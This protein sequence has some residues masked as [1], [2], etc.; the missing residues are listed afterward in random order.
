MLGTY[1]ASGFSRILLL[2]VNQP[3]RTGKSVRPTMNRPRTHAV[4]ERVSTGGSQTRSSFQTLNYA[5]QASPAFSHFRE[6]RINQECPRAGDL[7]AVR[8]PASSTVR[9]G[10]AVRTRVLLIANASGHVG[11]SAQPRTDTR[12]R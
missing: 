6:N 7:A 11:G 4:A 8:S 12:L 3:C 10:E 2:T 5:L 1:S 9:T